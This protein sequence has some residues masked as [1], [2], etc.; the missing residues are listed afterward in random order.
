MDMKLLAFFILIFSLFS[1]VVLAQNLTLH[2]SVQGDD[3]NPG[4]EGKP[5]ASIARAA[6]LIRAAGSDF[7]TAHVIIHEGV[8]RLQQGVVINGLKNIVFS[9]V[10]NGNVTIIGSTTLT[11][12]QKLSKRHTLYKKNPEIGKKII[13]FDVSNIEGLTHEKLRLAG[14]SS[15]PELKDFRLHEL[16]VDGKPMPLSRWP[17]GDAYAE[18]T[19]SVVDSSTMLT[20]IQYTDE[21]ISSWNDEPNILLHGYWKYLWSDAYE[22][23][24]SIDRKRKI[25]W[26]NPPYNHYTF[27]ENK[28][29]AA[30]NVVSEI[31]QPGEWAYDYKAQKIFFY[32]EGDVTDSKIELSVCKDPLLSVEEAQ[33]ITFRNITFSNGAGPG[34]EIKNSSYVNVE[35]CIVNAFPQ[36]GIL[37]HG[38]YN[39]SIRG[40]EVFDTGRGA[41]IVNG[42]SYIT[43]EKGNFNIENCHLHHLSRIDK[44]Y[45]PGILVDGVGT[46]IRNCKMHDIPSSAI[47]L[48]GNDHLVEYNE[49]YDVV[50]ESDDQG[51]IDMWGTQNY[52]GNVIR[53]NYFYDVGPKGQDAI[54]SHCGRA[55]VRLDDAISG[56]FIYGNVFKNTSVGLFG[57]VQIHGGKDNI[58]WN[59]IIYNCE[60][61]VSFSPWSEQKWEEYTRKAKEFFMQNRLA[62][63]AQYPQM[64]RY[65]DDI[66]KNTLIGNV[67]INCEK[68][69]VRDKKGINTWEDN[70]EI[71]DEGADLERANYSLGKY[72][73]E[74]EGVQFIPIPFEKIGLKKQE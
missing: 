39:N 41:I 3:S 52:R 72:T 1:T 51:A 33:H 40:C 17:N 13:E 73:Q 26:L 23:V 63:I 62:Y 49:M 28:P 25:I 58:V 10:D 56:V 74:L 55:G 38:G 14:A 24:N 60:T 43:L 31:D 44:T 27:D 67:L 66:N 5:V 42:G 48:N 18:F 12:F 50:T 54:N 53:Y 9:G 68:N 69:K 59:N 70:I 32:P 37:V 11:S 35:N 46:T 22:Q 65:D 64:I 19:H 71:N 15:V 34:I 57:A 8:Y 2:V 61:G 7:D 4:T 29:F 6:E 47:R 20:G 36:D 16:I 21:H 30:V 45:T